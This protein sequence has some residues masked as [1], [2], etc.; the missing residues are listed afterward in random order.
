MA[1]YF[2]ADIHLSAERP[3]IT[4][5]F[6][7]TLAAL[8]RDAGAVYILGDLFDYYLGD[9]LASPLQQ[10]IA[11]ALAALPCPVY[12]QHGNRD[13]LLGDTYA[14][15]ANMHILPERHRLSLGGKTVLLEH[16]DLLCTDDHGYQRLRRILRCR[17]LQRL[18]YRLPARWRLAIAEKLRGQSRKRT[19][20]K[21]SRIT[22][23]NP[24][25]IRRVLQEHQRQI[26]SSTATPTAPPCTRWMT[27][28]LCTSSATGIRMGKSSATTRTASASSTAPACRRYS[29]FK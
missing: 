24:A 6:R 26:S 17:F 9:D 23:T 25:T 21:A 1:E 3:D 29:R 19:R 27:A 15:A 7:A 16:G 13:F 11:A 12:Y 14:C 28:Q 10:D 5:A 18:Y 8:A 2:L 4:A 22:D 20:R